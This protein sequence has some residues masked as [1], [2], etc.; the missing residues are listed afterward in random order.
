V[1]LHIQ[2]KHKHPIAESF[3]FGVSY[4]LGALGC[5]FPLFLVVV[6]QAL[7]AESMV[8]GISYIVAYFLGLCLM[9]LL[10][11][12]GTMYS[13]KMIQRYIRSVLPYMNNFT[14]IILILA[15]IYIIRYQLILF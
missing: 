14:A 2:H 15:G 5:L 13:K 1:N 4:A 12:V 3:F 8:V 9:M 7:S 6:T 11:I 10:V